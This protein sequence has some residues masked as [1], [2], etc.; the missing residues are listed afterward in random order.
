M[1]TREKDV[2]RRNSAVGPRTQVRNFN[3]AEGQSNS[4]SKRSASQHHTNL[5][6]PLMKNEPEVDE[7]FIELKNQ[8]NFG[9]KKPSQLSDEIRVAVV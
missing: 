2:S 6:Y 7:D 4:L 3:R 5:Q 1:A 8:S 9:R